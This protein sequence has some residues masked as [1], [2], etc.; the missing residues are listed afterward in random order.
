M[1]LFFE[2]LVKFLI[3]LKWNKGIKIRKRMNLDDISFSWLGNYRLFD[4]DVKVMEEN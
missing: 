4:E 3:E 2:F 1:K